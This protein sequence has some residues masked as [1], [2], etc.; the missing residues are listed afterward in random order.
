MATRVDGGGGYSLPR[1]MM[2]GHHAKH[3]LF[4]LDVGENVAMPD[5]APGSTG[6]INTEYRSPGATLIVSAQYGL[7]SGSRPW[8]RRVG[9]TG[10]NAWDGFAGPRCNR[11][12]QSSRLR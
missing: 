11:W 1:T 6:L 5:H 7:S 8:R 9:R 4:P 2:A 12:R 10:A 3:A